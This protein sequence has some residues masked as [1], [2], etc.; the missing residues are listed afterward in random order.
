MFA[1][2]GRTINLWYENFLNKNLFKLMT[3]HHQIIPQ[4][5]PHFISANIT[6]LSYQPIT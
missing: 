1:T 5:A 4:K 2:F 3:K 6:F